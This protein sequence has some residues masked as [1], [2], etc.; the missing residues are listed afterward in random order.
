M[1]P[2]W[3]ERIA[4]LESDQT[5]ESVKNAIT[6]FRAVLKNKSKL[7]AGVVHGDLNL[8]NIIGQESSP[9]TG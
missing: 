5:T 7:P 9:G 6:D 2:E 8:L 3:E 1:N 4:T